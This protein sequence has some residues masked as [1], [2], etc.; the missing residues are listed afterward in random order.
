MYEVGSR[1]LLLKVVLRK[2]LNH[3]YTLANAIFV[4]DLLNG[5]IVL[6]YLTQTSSMAQQSAAVLVFSAIWLLQDI[7]CSFY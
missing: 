2:L 4:T 3:V 1:Q 6:I 5:L 7:L